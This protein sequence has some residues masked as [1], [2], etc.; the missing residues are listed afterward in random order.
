MKIS[1]IG[2]GAMGSIYAALMAGTR[3]EITLIDSWKEHINTIKTRGLKIEGASGKRLIHNINAST[4]INEAKGSELYII[5][6]K[7]PQVKEVAA[8]L[9]KFFKAEEK[10][11]TIQNGL[12]SGDEIAQYIDPKNIFIG[13]AEGFGAS[14]IAPGQV[15]H[16]SMKLIR[17]GEMVQKDFSRVKDLTKIWAASGF[18]AKAFEDIN[19]L[20][21]EKFICNV[22][23]SGPCAIFEITLGELMLVPEYWNIALSCMQ[24]AYK[25][26]VK[27]SVSFSFDDP[28]KYV[29]AFG[30]RMPKAKP[31]ML[32]DHEQKRFSEINAINGMAV[33]LGKKLGINTPYN[34]VITTLINHKE[35]MM[36]EYENC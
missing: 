23:F 29:T 32:L 18:E 3:H 16:N 8:K 19:Q 20:V 33:K 13:V 25:I 14:V 11:L 6:T 36:V 9:Q 12:G 35:K 17:I 26:G 5:S 30:E 27:K 31:S 1:I 4:D 10:I 21:W 28:V 7:T 15:H 22:T 34:E 2:G 24:E